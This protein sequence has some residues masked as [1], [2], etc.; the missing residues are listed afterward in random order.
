[1]GT[2]SDLFLLPLVR[3]RTCPLVFTPAVSCSIAAGWSSSSCGDMAPNLPPSRTQPVWVR[4][5]WG[6]WIYYGTKRFSRQEPVVAA[7]LAV[8]VLATATMLV[9]QWMEPRE[10]GGERVL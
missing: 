2:E 9:A 10:K 1:M 8:T 3:L 6:Q 7:S 4:P 5:T